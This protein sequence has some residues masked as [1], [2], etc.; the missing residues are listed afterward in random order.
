MARRT[1][2]DKGV[3]AL[4]ARSARY[5]FPDPELRGHY[6]RVA[7]GG[8]KSFVAVALNPSGRQVW[9]T[10]GPADTFTIADA[11]TQARNII[12]RTREGKP[13]IEPKAETFAAVAES[14]M[15]R[16]VRKNGL[17]SAPEIERMLGRHVLP[18]WGEREFLSIRRSDVATLLDRVEDAHGGRAADYVLTTVRSLMNWFAARND[19]YTPP[20]VRGMRRQDP[21]AHARARILDDDEI[22]AIWEAAEAGGTFGAIVRLCL[23]TAQR[24]RKVAR[25][26]WADLATDGEWHVTVDAREKGTGGALVLP[27]AAL[28][29]VAERP[30]IGDNPYVFPGRAGGAFNGFSQGKARFDA[31]LPPGMSPWVVHDL[32][33]T[34]RSLMSR[35]GVQK[36]IAER[37]LGHAIAGIE[38][39]YDR[40]TYRSE[41]A[42]ALQ[43]LA[44]LVDIIR[45]PPAR[46][47]VALREA[48]R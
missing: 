41:K 16:H 44:A 11:R 40:H 46:N 19:D 30:R 7:P 1:L 39:V 36:D 12:R 13:P 15:A 25:M 4:K 42:D 22:R 43:R 31:T 29:I 5:A 14:W 48:A 23:L 20:I 3:A 38:G 35:A 2:S 26:R 24:S 45:R 18:A 27:P 28:A 8:A 37:V 34:A 21:R 10:I 47:V 9:T 17:R 33:R 32:R 6:V